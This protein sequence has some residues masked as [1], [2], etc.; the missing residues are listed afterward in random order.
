MK[1]R[2][3]LG[4]D[5]NN[6]WMGL[7]SN[8]TSGLKPSLP[9]PRQDVVPHVIVWVPVFA[10]I[11]VV[12]LAIVAGIMLVVDVVP[13]IAVMVVVVLVPFIV[14]DAAAL[15]TIMVELVQAVVVVMYCSRAETGGCCRARGCL[16]LVVL[17]VAVV[18]LIVSVTVVVALIWV[19]SLL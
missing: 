18:V 12:V 19:K 9:R 11:M 15:V 3:Y 10:D 6:G 1:V 17:V 4:R 13:M 14:I 5:R 7:P 2:R 16:M 8:W